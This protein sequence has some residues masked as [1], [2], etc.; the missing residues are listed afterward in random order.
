MPQTMTEGPT[1][2]ELGSGWRWRAHHS[3]QPGASTQVDGY[4]VDDGERLDGLDIACVGD[5][6]AN[7]VD[8]AAVQGRWARCGV[9]IDRRHDVTTLIV[10]G[11]TL[12]FSTV[13]LALRR[14]KVGRA[15]EL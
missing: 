10:P 12:S 15:T 11:S 8:P 5:E 2:L 9:V 6:D 7:G 1:S 13:Y 14:W 4:V 3:W